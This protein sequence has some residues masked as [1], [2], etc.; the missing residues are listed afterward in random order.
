ML[1]FPILIIFIIV[2]IFSIK[3]IKKYKHDRPK[4]NIYKFLILISILIS[5]G[6]VTLGLLGIIFFSIST[7]FIFLI[8][9]NNSLKNLS[10]DSVW[11]IALFVTSLWPIGLIFGYL[12]NSIIDFKKFFLFI[13]TGY[14]LVILGYSIFIEGFT[15]L[16]IDQQ[17]TKF[18]LSFI[19]L[20]PVIPLI[21]YTISK[22]TERFDNIGQ[23]S[24]LF[25]I[26]IIWGNLIS[27]LF[28][29]LYA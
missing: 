19:Y 17:F 4:Q 10:G 23:Y 21:L 29:T 6:L 14:L 28:Y 26:Q 12:I 7:Q 11:P 5:F 18:Q 27:L 3:R 8:F 15:N 24:L 16:F 2:I 22:F 9:G 25:I 13:F 20:W 1:L